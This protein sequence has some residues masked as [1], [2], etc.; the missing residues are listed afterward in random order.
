MASLHAS[1]DE[2]AGGAQILKSRQEFDEERRDP[3]GLHRWVRL[4]H[5]STAAMNGKL[6]EALFSSNADSRIGVRVAPEA[7]AK[8]IRPVNLSPLSG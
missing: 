2:D 8:A 1:F 3:L 7:V 4:V 5:V 6:A